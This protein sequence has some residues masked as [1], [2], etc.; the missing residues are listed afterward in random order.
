M[1]PQHLLP[2]D[3]TGKAFWRHPYAERR[4]RFWRD[5][6]RAAFIGTPAH[7][8]TMRGLYAASMVGELTNIQRERNDRITGDVKP[9]ERA[10]LAAGFRKCKPPHKDWTKDALTPA[11]GKK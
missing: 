3:R 5:F 11:E 6:E 2:P 4:D 9:L 7:T 8:G 10:L 1:T